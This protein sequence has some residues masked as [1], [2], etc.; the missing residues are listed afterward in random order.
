MIYK[1]VSEIK[2]I[3]TANN[4]ELL[5][6]IICVSRFPKNWYIIQA[7]AVVTYV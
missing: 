4:Y 7:Y 3:K 1:Y 6:N 5:G 2:L